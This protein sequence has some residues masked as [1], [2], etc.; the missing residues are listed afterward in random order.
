MASVALRVRDDRITA[1]FGSEPT[2]TACR[3]FNGSPLDRIP[4]SMSTG[5]VDSSAV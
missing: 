1:D 5:S 2:S 3:Y 4:T